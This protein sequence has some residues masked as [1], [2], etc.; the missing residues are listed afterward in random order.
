MPCGAPTQYCRNG[1][2]RSYAPRRVWAALLAPPVT[3]PLDS[4]VYIQAVG[5]IRLMCK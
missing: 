2:A 4:V 1:C 5:Y 3:P